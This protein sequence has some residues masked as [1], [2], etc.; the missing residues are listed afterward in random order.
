METLAWAIQDQDLGVGG[1]ACPAQSDVELTMGE[2]GT[3]QKDT[4]FFAE[5]L[6]LGLVDGH[7]ESQFDGEL[8]RAASR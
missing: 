8:T 7:S 5:A 6:T 1:D 4:D 2:N 3:W